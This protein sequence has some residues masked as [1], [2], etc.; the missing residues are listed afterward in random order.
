VKTSMVLFGISVEIS[1]IAM[2]GRVV[3]ALGP[4]QEFYLTARVR[5]LH[6]ETRPRVVNIARILIY[7]KNGGN[8][9]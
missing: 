9:G 2:S 7:F 6:P 1:F 4:P 5:L 3:Q 8:V